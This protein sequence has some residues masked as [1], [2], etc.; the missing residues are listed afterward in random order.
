MVNKNFKMKIYFILFLTF[1]LSNNSID[2]NQ[3]TI[4][5]D[6]I[7]HETIN[8]SGLFLLSDILSLSNQ[9]QINT[10]DGFSWFANINNLDISNSNY[11]DIMIDNHKMDINT[12]GINNINFLPININEIDS[13]EII[14][15]P[16][17]YKGIFAQSGLI[18]I[19]TKNNNDNIIISSSVSNKTGDPGPYLYF[20]SNN[21]PN[22][23][24]GGGKGTINFRY[25]NK[26]NY[27]RY[28]F[29]Y[30]YH[31]MTDW[32]IK[33]RIRNIDINNIDYNNPST[34]EAIS[35]FLN[36][37]RK[38]NNS[39]IDLFMNY[40]FSDK[41]F[42]FL[43]PIG[44]EI[45]TKYINTY[46]GINYSTKLSD[47]INLFYK[48]NHST[49]QLK[50][51]PNTLN[52]NFDSHIEN[53]HTSIENY[54]KIFK[55]QFLLGF[56]FN[57]FKLNTDYILNQYYYDVYKVFSSFNYKLNSKIENNA[58][59]MFILSNNEH[60]FNVSNSILFNINNNN[61]INFIIS[62][63][64]K[65][66]NNNWYWSILDYNLSN[67]NDLD[68]IK[69]NKNKIF[70]FDLVWKNNFFENIKFEF[71]NYFRTFKDMQF[72]DYAYQFNSQNE[73]ILLDSLLFYNNQFFEIFGIN[74]S[75]NHKINQKI[76]Y[77]LS[78]NIITN[79]YGS[80]LLMDNFKKIPNKSLKYHL[81]YSIEENFSIWL[82]F[83]YLSDSFWYDYQFLNGKVYES[84]NDTQL[85]YSNKINQS[86]IIDIGFEKWFLNEKIKTNLFLRNILNENYRY[87]PVGATFDL[88]LYFELVFYPI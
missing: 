77:F 83:N 73:F 6:V 54:F 19:Y 9:I 11:W 55:A 72:E 25:K 21:S 29:N 47:K 82:K 1:L 42:L 45:P 65:N 68:T 85:F 26:N 57:R 61:N 86:N 24:H 23:E 75:F 28:G 62:Y 50:K 70:T 71:K 49:N 41:H 35:T 38:T 88:S 15:S 63:I 40:N 81:T 8:K 16:Q 60:A 39:D 59:A 18:H 17:L 34:I 80:D 2:Y 53:F 27:Y 7:Y 33:E 66:I 4:N 22:V 43:K 30:H 52:I 67:L 56:S 3:N 12:F 69:F 31:H 14:T 74:F 36:W 37:N 76:K 46:L 64:E 58:N 78:Y 44:M 13:I 20:Q 5:R 51:Y 84:I 48:I 87:H 10:I 79:S 32:S